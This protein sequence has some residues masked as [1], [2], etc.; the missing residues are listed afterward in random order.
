MYEQPSHYIPAVST[1][2]ARENT[3]RLPFP[4]GRCPRGGTRGRPTA[5]RLCRSNRSRRTASFRR[6]RARARCWHPSR[7]RTRS[8]WGAEDGEATLSTSACTYNVRMGLSHTTP[9]N[10]T[11]HT[12]HRTTPHYTTVH[13]STRLFYYVVESCTYAACPF[14][15]RRRASSTGGG[16]P[17]GR[18][19]SAGRARCAGCGEPSAEEQKGCGRK[20]L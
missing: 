5:R 8:T 12:P 3:P 20:H 18:A 19:G 7:T 9:H 14:G 6:R 1:R 17:S 16:T 4:R 13:D 10:S 2:A 15:R 11:T